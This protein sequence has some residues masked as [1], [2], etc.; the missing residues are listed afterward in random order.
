METSAFFAL[1][2]LTLLRVEP[3]DVGGAFRFALPHFQ[4]NLYLL[5]RYRTSTRC[6]QPDGPP[7]S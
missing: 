1:P 6:P 4:D 2:V 3:G 5:T 7:P